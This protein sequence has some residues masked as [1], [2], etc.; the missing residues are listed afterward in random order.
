VESG[1]SN[2]EAIAEADRCLRCYRVATIAV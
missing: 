1:F 2:S